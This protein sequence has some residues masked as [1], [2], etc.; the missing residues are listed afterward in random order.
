MIPFCVLDCSVTMAWCFA[1]DEKNS[2]SDAVLE[3]L[4]HRSALAPAIWPL[5]VANVVLVG[6]RRKRIDADSGTLFLKSLER[7]PV[8]VDT[9]PFGDRW[10]D[11]IQLARKLDISVYD[12]SYLELALRKKTPLATLDKALTRA[13]PAAG[14]ALFQPGKP[15]R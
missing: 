11:L 1:S 15:K 6:E 5:E 7:L 9:V 3:T 8:D 14:V 12:A 10:L 2:L 4:H 13:A